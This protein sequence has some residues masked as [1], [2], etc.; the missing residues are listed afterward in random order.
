MKE[1]LRYLTIGEIENLLH[2]LCKKGIV[3]HPC[4]EKY[5]L[6]LRSQV[7]DKSQIQSRVPALALYTN[8]KK[9]NDD[10]ADA[11]KT[12]SKQGIQKLKLHH[13]REVLKY[14]W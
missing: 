11:V 6:D 8:I 9:T 7:F 5:L 1:Q 3:L 13:M 4:V 12:A 10:D 2:E 14:L